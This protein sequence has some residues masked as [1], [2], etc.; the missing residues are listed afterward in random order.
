MLLDMYLFFCLPFPQLA[1]PVAAASRKTR[2]GSGRRAPADTG[3]P[4]RRRAKVDGKAGF[5]QRAAS[6][7][8]A[9]ARRGAGK[10]GK[11]TEGKRRSAPPPLRVIEGGRAGIP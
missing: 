5:G 7:S 6:G 4:S 9:P 8:R 2:A 3:A 10:G 1:R 11:G